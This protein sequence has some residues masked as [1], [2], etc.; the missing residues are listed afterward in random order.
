MENL[1]GRYFRV[2]IRGNFAAREKISE[3]LREN[4]R[5]LFSAISPVE[6]S[7][8][9]VTLNPA[10]LEREQERLRISQWGCPSEPIAENFVRDEE[11][12]ELRFVLWI[13]SGYPLPA[14]SK[15]H[16]R[17]PACEIFVEQVAS[18]FAV[19]PGTPYFRWPGK[20]FDAV[21]TGY[22]VA[23]APKEEPESN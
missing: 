21:V 10:N 4:Q 6:L 2:T 5:L 7:L 11:N 8:S 3:F 16:D 15:L 18:F 20:K 13:R 1:F 9:T 17:Y 22:D 19:G 23:P 14:L 12:G